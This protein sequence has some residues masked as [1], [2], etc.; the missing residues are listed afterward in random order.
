VGIHIGWYSRMNVEQKQGVA[1]SCT[2]SESFCLLCRDAFNQI[3]MTF[4]LF[5]VLK[6]CV[7]K[8]M[9]LIYEYRAVQLQTTKGLHCTI[10]V[11]HYEKEGSSSA[12]SDLDRYVVIRKLLHFTY[13]II[14]VLISKWEIQTYLQRTFLP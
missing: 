6:V 3:R 4:R 14:L 9:L 10:D 7:A 1:F 13:H 5:D 12:L 11:L 8:E 2:Y